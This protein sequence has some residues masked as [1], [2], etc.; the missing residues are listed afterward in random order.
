MHPLTILMLL[1][2]IVHTITD[3]QQL[4][5]VINNDTVSNNSTY[6]FYPHSIAVSISNKETSYEIISGRLTITD[7]SGRHQRYSVALDSS[8]VDEKRLSATFSGCKI[9]LEINSIRNLKTGVISRPNLYSLIHLSNSPG[10]KLNPK[11][12]ILINN[13]LQYKKTGISS[14]SIQSFNIVFPSFDVHDSIDVLYVAGNKKVKH[15]LRAISLIN[16][17]ELLRTGVP[18]GRFIITIYDKRNDLEKLFVIAI[19]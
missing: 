11:G 18:G 10:H 14:D 7:K 12:D 8:H 19:F 15:R 4:T 6:N 9:L 1:F 5:V 16:N 3:A 13:S 17:P 2:L